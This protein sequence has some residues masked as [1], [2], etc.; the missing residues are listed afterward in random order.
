[1][2]LHCAIPSFSH[3]FDSQI[4]MSSFQDALSA[5]ASTSVNAVTIPSISPLAAL[6]SLKTSSVAVGTAWMISSAVFT[7]Y[8]ATKFLKFSYFENENQPP[9]LLSQRKR[10]NLH[11][12]FM[13]RPVNRF[14]SLPPASMLTMYRFAGSLLLGLLLH[15]DLAVV[16]RFRRTL[17]AVPA[18]ALP[19]TFLFVANFAN[20]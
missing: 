14:V 16:D 2:H 18:L 15:P 12:P 20:S 3:R 11:R 7:T 6:F 17:A 19:A 10:R 9:G 4:V 5:A 13:Q 1:M 8:T